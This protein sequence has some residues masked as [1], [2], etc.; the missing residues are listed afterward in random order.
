MEQS[1]G[2]RYNDADD[3]TQYPRRHL[4]AQNGEKQTTTGT[5]NDDCGTTGDATFEGFG[6]YM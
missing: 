1:S 6:G 5:G 4:T 3:P 2:K